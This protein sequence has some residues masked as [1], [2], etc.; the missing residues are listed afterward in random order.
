MAIYTDIAS[1]IYT[2]RKGS[3]PRGVAYESHTSGDITVTSVQVRRSGLRRPKGTYI[4][5][6]L[7][8]FERIDERN[9][10][11][12]TAVT[13]QLRRL[14]PEKE[15]VLVVGFGDGR[16]SA[17]ALGPRTV[18]EIFVTRG[19]GP[20]FTR[21]LPALR[22]VA[23]LALGPAG[24][25]GLSAPERLAPLVKELC[26]GAVLCIDALCT[27]SPAR[28][29]CT[30]QISDAGLQ[31]GAGLGS[32]AGEVNAEALGVPVIAVGV[33]TVMDAAD[34]CPGSRGLIV[35]PREVRQV[36]SRAAKV[37]SLSVNR[38]LQKNLTTGELRF[39]VS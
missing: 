13:A 23:A 30:V 16:F 3:L 31:P 17:D 8:D 32:C 11:Y 9:E 28:L 15:P 20:A 26:F 7:P 6:E 33:P 19:F 27:K 38:A 29:G 18:E 36:V 2:G 37:L 5:V 21:D 24:Q 4:T 39:L 1:E 22:P 25:T 35:T 10:R 12:I 34:C 14:L